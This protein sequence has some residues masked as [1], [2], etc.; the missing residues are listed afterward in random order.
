MWRDILI[1][2]REELLEQSKIFQATLHSLEK[3]I[4]SGDGDALEARIDQASST[5]A[6]W[7]ISL[8][9]SPK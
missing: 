5:R 4:A 3:L 6:N 1:A 9:K 7:R 2:N 8:P